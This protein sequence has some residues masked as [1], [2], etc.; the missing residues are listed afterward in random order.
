MTYQEWKSLKGIR[1]E[2]TKKVIRDFERSNPYLAAMYE[3][4]QEEEVQ[5]MRQTMTI[6]DRMERWKKIAELNRDPNF[7]ARR[8]REEM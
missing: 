5:Q 8:K 3:K 2:D 1:G 7:I 6:N 4:Q